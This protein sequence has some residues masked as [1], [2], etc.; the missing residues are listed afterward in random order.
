MI[1]WQQ[2]LKE[3]LQSRLYYAMSIG[4]NPERSCTGLRLLAE[5]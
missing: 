5:Y 3:W 4:C 1:V 2:W